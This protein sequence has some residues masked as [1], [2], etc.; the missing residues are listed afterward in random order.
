[1]KHSPVSD[2]DRLAHTGRLAPPI[3]TITIEWLWT[4]LA[5]ANGFA[6]AF[7][8]GQS[9]ERSV[10]IG[11]VFA[12]IYCVGIAIG[13]RVR[14]HRQVRELVL[15]I[16]PMPTSIQTPRP[17]RSRKQA[18]VAMLV[19][20]VVGFVAISGLMWKLR[21][22]YDIFKHNVSSIPVR[23]EGTSTPGM[24]A[25]GR[26]TPVHE[27]TAPAT[28]AALETAPATASWPTTEPPL[29]RL[30]LQ[31]ARSQVWEVR[32]TWVRCYRFAIPSKV[33]AVWWC[34]KMVYF[35]EGS[36]ESMKI[37]RVTS[38]YSNA[39]HGSASKT[40]NRHKRMA[41]TGG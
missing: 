11:T 9:T 2:F 15:A 36:L 32:Q 34:L 38:L 4:F 40:L 19:T 8:F 10:A 3:R 26:D 20:Q 18:S 25:M 16:G 6:L 28:V 24:I 21:P 17:L 12:S 23:I 31:Q 30:D 5:Y 41:W 1:M 13:R 7:I 39:G 22:N 37:P 29:P 33:V 27:T 14:K 35:C